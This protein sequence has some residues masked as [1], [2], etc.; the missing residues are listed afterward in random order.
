MPA[1]GLKPARFTR[2]YRD[3]EF[4]FIEVDTDTY[5]ECLKKATNTVEDPI[6]GRDTEEVDENLALRLLLRKS[7]IKPK[8]TDWNLGTRLMR[9]LERDV[10]ELHFGTEPQDKD[11][12]KKQVENEDGD[13]GSPNSEG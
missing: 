9:Q 12:Q 6:T 7:L 3:T 11:K 1:R 10:R 8:I 2:W 4:E 5:D 13:D